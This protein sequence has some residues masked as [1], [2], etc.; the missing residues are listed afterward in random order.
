M[1]TEITITY[2]DRNYVLGFSRNTAKQIVVN[3]GDKILWYQ[4]VEID[5]SVGNLNDRYGLEILDLNFDGQLDL[6]IAEKVED[7]LVSSL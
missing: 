6:M 5:K 7:Q 2:K 1:A 3:E 4:T